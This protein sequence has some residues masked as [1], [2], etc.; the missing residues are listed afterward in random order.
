MKKPAH[1]IKAE[2][3]LFFITFLWGGTFVLIKT[4]L[5]HIS[6]MVF[7]SVRFGLASI[8]LLPFVIKHLFAATKSQYKKA[9]ILGLSLFVGFATQTIGLRYTTATKSAF[10]TGM[11]VIITPIM[12]I[13]LERRRPTK[14]NLFAILLGFFGILF[15]SS[16]GT[17]LYQ[18]LFELGTGFN[19]GDFLTLICAANYSWYIVY[20][21]MLGEDLNFKFLTFMQ[22]FV[23]MI[24]ALP[25]VFFFNA[26]GVEKAQFDLFPI[27]IVAIIYTAIFTTILSTLLQTKFQKD[28]SPTRASIIFS[29]EPMYATVSAVFLIGEKLSIF[30]IIGCCFIFSGVLISELSLKE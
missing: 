26:I 6:P 19:F 14:R 24:L 17:N 11:F 27:V 18:V 30:G 10:L 4:A 3:A 7:V 2:A 1:V 22:I 23:T 15:L 21:D 20:L 12:Q 28:V 25:F 8:I 29:M 9:I 16:R 13:A 5:V